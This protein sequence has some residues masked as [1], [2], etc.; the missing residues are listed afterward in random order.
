MISGMV[1]PHAGMS[2][3]DPGQIPS[4]LQGLNPNQRTAVKQY[5]GNIAAANMDMPKEEAADI[6]ARVVRIQG[7]KT[8]VTHV[9]PDGKR[10]LDYVTDP[11]SGRAWIWVGNTYR[12]FYTA[13][14]M[15]DE[16]PAPSP[17]SPSSG[18]GGGG[19]SEPP[20]ASVDEMNND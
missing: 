12:P 6:A 15:T 18:A 8:P 9:G 10:A 2:Q 14:N 11:K 1:N 3:H 7:S 19:G 20:G 4:A 17:M 5:G 13:P 16:G